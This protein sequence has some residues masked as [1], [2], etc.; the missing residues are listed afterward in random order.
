MR[1]AIAAAAA[2]VLTACQEIPQDTRKPFVPESDAKAAHE[3]A[4]RERAHLQDEYL[5][6]RAK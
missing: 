1:L 4:P 2:F 5:R 3:K 6:L